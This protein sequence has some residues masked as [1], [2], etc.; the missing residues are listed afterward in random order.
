MGCL[1]ICVKPNFSI[2]FKT[3][4]SDKLLSTVVFVFSSIVSVSQT[5]IAKNIIDKIVVGYTTRWDVE[6]S[7]GKGER[8]DQRFLSPDN[9]HNIGKSGWVHSNGLR[10]T[11]KG[12][13]FICADDGE[14]ISSIYLNAPYKFVLNDVD[15]S[16]FK[17]SAQRS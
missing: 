3:H 14:K 2:N 11:E 9:E 6:Q 8:L 17:S 16:W 5:N 13:T 1:R 12:F 4:P 7:F 10:Y 15:P